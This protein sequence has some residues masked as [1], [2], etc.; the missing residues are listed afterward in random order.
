MGTFALSR[1]HEKAVFVKADVA[2]RHIQLKQSVSPRFHPHSQLS[3][4]RLGARWGSSLN[5][6]AAI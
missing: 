6:G 5:L 1:F 3:H 2:A 4:L